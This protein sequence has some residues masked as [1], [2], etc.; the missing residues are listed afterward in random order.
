MGL[1]I[2]EKEHPPPS[3]VEIGGNAVVGAR[4][5]VGIGG[6]GEGFQGLGVRV[7]VGIMRGVG[8]L[9][10]HVILHVRCCY[11]LSDPSLDLWQPN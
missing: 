1:S 5:R 11:F 9:N 7:R 8:F 2:S 3:P 4:V 6:R 10:Y